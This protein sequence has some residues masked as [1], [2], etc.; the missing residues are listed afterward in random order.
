MNAKTGLGRIALH[1]AV[2]GGHLETTKSLIE[3][4]SNIN[5][6][7]NEFYTPLHFAAE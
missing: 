2:Q 4:N 1:Y 5:E 7:D 6:Q 3:A